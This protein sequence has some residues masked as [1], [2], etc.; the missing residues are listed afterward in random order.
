MVRYW[1]IGTLVLLVCCGN[2]RVGDVFA[3]SND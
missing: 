3:I 2:M 1:L